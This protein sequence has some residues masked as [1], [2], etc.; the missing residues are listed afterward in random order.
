MADAWARADTR[1]PQALLEGLQ[2]IDSQRFGVPGVPETAGLSHPVSHGGDICRPLGVP[3]VVAPESVRL[4]LDELVTNNRRSLAP[5]V[6]DG[7]TFRATDIDWRAGQGPEVSAPATAILAAL[8][9]RITP[10]E[11]GSA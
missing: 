10:E 9:G 2:G 3:H 5:G 1:S 6:I 4:V 8:L 11:A 7:H